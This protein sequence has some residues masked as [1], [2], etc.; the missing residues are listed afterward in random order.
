MN[1]FVIGVVAALACVCGLSFSS[2]T[3]APAP[4]VKRTQWEYKDVSHGEL[5]KVAFQNEE[6]AKRVQE[7]LGRS[8]EKPRQA[9]ESDV[10]HVD[11]WEAVACNAFGV[12]GLELAAITGQDEK[13]HYIFKR[14]VK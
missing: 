12:D 5:R 13:Q 1:R 11:G 4:E 9:K 14:P 2:E 10:E 7:F 3:A 8:Y 6:L